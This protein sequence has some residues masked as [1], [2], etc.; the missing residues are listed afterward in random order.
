MSTVLFGIKNCDTVKKA[1]RFLTTHDIPFEFSDF[2]DE[3]PTAEQI[4][5]WIAVLGLDTL[6]NKRS[7]TFRQL[8]DDA[9][10]SNDA[11]RWVGLI[12]QQPTLIKRPL[13]KHDD[14]LYC[15]FSD[16]KYQEIFHV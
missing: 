14:S 3:Q 16:K 13:L 4:Q 11:E 7:T 5:S 1:Q 10:Q 9:K 2:R 6:V 8:D 15:G 12:Q